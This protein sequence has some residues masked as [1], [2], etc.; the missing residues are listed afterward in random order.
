MHHTARVLLMGT[1]VDAIGN[2]AGGTGAPA[3]LSLLNRRRQRVRNGGT[4]R[5]K[6]CTIGVLLAGIVIPLTIASPA[7]AD[8]AP[9]HAYYG[10]RG[11][12]WTNTERTRVGVEDQ[13]SDGIMIA[14]LVRT[15]PAGNVYRLFDA[16]NS[17]PGHSAAPIPAGEL[18]DQIWVCG[19]YASSGALRSCGGVVTVTSS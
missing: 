3:V 15:L 13:L 18:I 17:D 2:A 6:L 7:H 16:N 14:V 4:M 5:K 10:N 1:V 11:H 12:G 9:A 19:Y 8:P